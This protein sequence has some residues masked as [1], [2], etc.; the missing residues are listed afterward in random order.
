MY[1]RFPSKMV[2]K[3]CVL[4]RG[5]GVNLQLFR[6]LFHLV[7]NERDPIWIHLNSQETIVRI[8]K[9]ETNMRILLGFKDT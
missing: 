6:S 4:G 1:F 3:F 7:A 2:L 8:L 5:W 9:F